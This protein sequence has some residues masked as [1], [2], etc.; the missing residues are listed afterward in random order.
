MSTTSLT[1]KARVKAGASV[2]QDFKT[3]IWPNYKVISDPSYPIDPDIEFECILKPSG[4]W[5][6]KASGFG[7]LPKY[8][9]GSLYV[10]AQD[11]DIL[12]DES[13]IT[14][15]SLVDKLEKSQ[16]TAQIVDNNM[17]YIAVFNLDTCD[18]VAAYIVVGDAVL[19]TSSVP[20]YLKD[21]LM[22]HIKE[23]PISTIHLQHKKS[24]F[25][26]QSDVYTLVYQAVDGYWVAGSGLASRVRVHTMYY[27]DR[28]TEDDR[29]KKTGTVD[30]IYRAII[31]DAMGKTYTVLI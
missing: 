4:T 2:W 22:P 15:Q 18:I 9:N 13:V 19:I 7:V 25:S 12:T 31:N 17:T 21:M 5:D 24:V 14:I 11:L 26:G 27:H 6:C 29:E 20:V 16:G 8:G 23:Y 30:S 3:F 1:V 28:M 10:A